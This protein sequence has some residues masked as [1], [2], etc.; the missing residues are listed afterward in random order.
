MILVEVVVDGVVAKLVAMPS[1]VL[2]LRLAGW[3]DK[4]VSFNLCYLDFFFSVLFYLSFLSTK[5]WQQ[6]FL[7]RPPVLLLRWLGRR[8]SSSG[9][10]GSQI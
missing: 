1:V 10:G 6:I 3:R 8:L 4:L 5:Y 9:C 7:R 2:L